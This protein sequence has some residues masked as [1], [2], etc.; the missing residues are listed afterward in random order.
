MSSGNFARGNQEPTLAESLPLISACFIGICA[1]FSMSVMV[2]PMLIPMGREFGMSV[3]ALGQ[4]ATLTFLPWGISAVLIGPISD[5]YGRKKVL[6]VG[7]AG[8]SLSGI[9]ASIAP[10][11]LTLAS[12]RVLTGVC[13]GLIPPSCLAALTDHFTGA[14]RGYAI[15][16]GSAGYSTSWLLGLPLVALLTEHIGWRGAFMAAAALAAGTFLLISAIFPAGRKN[17]SP[18]SYFGSFAWMRS[19]A[20][21]YAIGAN[22]MERAAIAIFFTYVAAFM[23]I[24]YGLSPSALAWMLMAMTVGN[25]IGNLPGGAL[26]GR[27]WRYEGLM[28]VVLIEGG[29]LGMNFSNMPPIGLAVA[30]GFLFSFLSAVS[31]PTLVGAFV[32]IAPENRG[33]IIGFFASSNQAGFV[34]GSS[35]GGL[36]IAWGG[37][38]TLGMLC[39]ALGA[40]G[41]I[42]YWLLKRE[43]HLQE[44]LVEIGNP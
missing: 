43:T 25:L 10:S 7:L 29:L 37:Y 32:N 11:Y 21:W 38:G 5:R 2:G 17:E 20:P 14:R 26:A 9:A 30:A 34:L 3:P 33:T 4:L 13:G 36:A 18:K 41:C 39:L 19:P 44:A 35:V 23:A 24:H 28:A 42:F 31:R 1:S 16:I 27:G 15:A 12:A 6:L 22:V 40:G 8:L